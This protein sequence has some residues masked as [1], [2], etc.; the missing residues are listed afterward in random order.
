MHKDVMK[1]HD[2][3]KLHVTLVQT[4]RENKAGYSGF[5]I[6]NTKLAREL[7]EKVGHP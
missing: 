5:Q 4:V 6:K 7:Y 3:K 2:T 1:Y